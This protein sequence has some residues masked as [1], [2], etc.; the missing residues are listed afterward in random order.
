MR[1]QTAQ[2][3]CLISEAGEM[4]AALRWKAQSRTP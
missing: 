1:R 2:A 3:A 4:P